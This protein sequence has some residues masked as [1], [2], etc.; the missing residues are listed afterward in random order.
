VSALLRRTARLASPR[1][2]LVLGVVVV[3]LVAAAVVMAVVSHDLSQGIIVIPFGVVGYVVARR[4]PRN[5]IGWILLATTLAFLLS[6][7]GGTYAVLHYH[8][9]YG[10]LPLARVGVFLAAWWIWL[11][12]LLP[13][14]V[15]LFPDARLSGAWRRVVWVYLG[16]V[17]VCIGALTWQDS[18]GIVAR[19]IRIDSNGELVS[20]GGSSGGSVVKGVVAGSFLL[21]CVACVARQI[22]R[23]RRSAGEQ[24]QQLKWL[25]SGGAISIGGLLLAMSISNSHNPVLH[26]V[27]SVGFG[28]I[29]ALPVGLGVGILKYRLYDIDRLISRTLSYALLSGLLIGT[30]AGLVLL[31]TRVLPFSSPVGVAAST[32]AAAGLFAPLRN[33]LQ[34]LVDR[35]FNRARYDADALVAAFGARLRD[36]VE[37]ETVLSELSAVAAGSLHPAHVSIWVRRPE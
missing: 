30:F 34:R 13:L 35:R 2:A 24:R 33:R 26:A 28:G 31:T 18:T 6:T 36:S 19:H 7:D 12:L 11:L 8:R 25:L 21:F 22:V 1:T 14:P 37:P 20:G 29:V 3:L 27:G 15:G 23:Y 32:L 10:G 4:E 5:P 9:G 17:A 16:L